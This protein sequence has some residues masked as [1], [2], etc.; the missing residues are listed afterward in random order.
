MLCAEC[1]HEG[2]VARLMELDE[3][4]PDVRALCQMR[5]DEIG[6]VGRQEPE[7][8]GLQHERIVAGN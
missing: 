2:T 8:V 5:C 6:F 7:H 4:V 3:T 1:R